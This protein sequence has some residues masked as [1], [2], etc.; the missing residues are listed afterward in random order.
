[1][2]CSGYEVKYCSLVAMGGGL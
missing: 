1:M 2:F